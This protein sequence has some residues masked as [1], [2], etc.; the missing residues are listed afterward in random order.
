MADDMGDFDVVKNATCSSDS[1]DDLGFWMGMTG[2]LGKLVGET[3]KHKDKDG[4]FSYTGNT[5]FGPKG[6]ATATCVKG[7]DDVKCG[8]C[9]GFAVGRVTKECSGK[10]SGSVELKICQVSFNKK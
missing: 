3:P 7:K 10:A 5:E 8:T 9:V 4:G 1:A 2:L 6:E